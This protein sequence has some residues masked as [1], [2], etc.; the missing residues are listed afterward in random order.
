[1]HITPPLAKF[2]KVFQVIML[3]N[4]LSKVASGGT[5]AVTPWR[6]N[7]GRKLKVSHRWQFGQAPCTTWSRLA[8]KRGIL[9]EL[10]LSFST[11]LTIIRKDALNFWNIFTLSSNP[12]VARGEN[13]SAAPS[14]ITEER[15]LCSWSRT[16]PWQVTRNT[17]AFHKHTVVF[18]TTW[19]NIYIRTTTWSH[20]M[21]TTKEH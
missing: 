4:Y 11:R 15:S 16:F 8:K 9:D 7:W 21:M 3:P 5:R 1:M 12:Y 18:L 10:S 17:Q 2:P 13:S 6:Q 20:N 14:A 19:H